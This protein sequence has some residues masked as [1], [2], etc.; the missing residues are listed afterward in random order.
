MKPKFHLAAVT[1]HNFCQLVKRNPLTDFFYHS[2][3]HLSSK[4]YKNVTFFDHFQL[5]SGF[6]FQKCKKI[7]DSHHL[8]AKM[9]VTH[10]LFGSK[11]SCRP[12]FQKW[13][14]CVFWCENGLKN[15]DPVP[16]SNFS[17]WWLKSG[18]QIFFLR[19]T[20]YFSWWTKT[21]THPQVAP[22]RIF[23]WGHLSPKNSLLC[24]WLTHGVKSPLTVRLTSAC[25]T[26]HLIHCLQCFRTSKYHHWTLKKLISNKELTWFFWGANL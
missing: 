26:T 15:V 2:R 19:M 7:I 5:F 25:A 16:V 11:S 24:D 20:K 13:D 12:F 21:P 18:T 17:G 3:G 14:S 9:S 1:T 23:A 6:F 4:F 10:F 8:W 22:R